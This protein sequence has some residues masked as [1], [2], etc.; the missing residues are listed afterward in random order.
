M[1]CHRFQSGPTNARGAALGGPPRVIHSVRL[2]PRSHQHV[3]LPVSHIDV[4]QAP[5]RVPRSERRLTQREV[6]DEDPLPFPALIALN[7]L[8][9]LPTDQRQVQQGD[10]LEHQTDDPQEGQAWQV[11][12]ASAVSGV[13]VA[14]GRASGAAAPLR[15]PAPPLPR[16]RAM[17]TDEAPAGLLAESL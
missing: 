5:A 13:N 12:G 16:P 9:P 10:A 14:A 1:L 6:A 8:G 2:L 4:T 15:R 11:Q 7:D 3:P 17:G